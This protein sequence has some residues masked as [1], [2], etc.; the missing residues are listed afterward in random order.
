MDERKGIKMPAGCG[1]ISTRFWSARIK[2][3]V[4]KL[5]RLRLRN[6]TFALESMVLQSY[7]LV[8]IFIK[9]EK[10]GWK[11]E[12]WTTNVNL[13]IANKSKRKKMDTE[14]CQKQLTINSTNT[15]KM[16]IISLCTRTMNDSMTMHIVDR[17]WTRTRTWTGTTEWQWQHSSFFSFSSLT[18][19]ATLNHLAKKSI[20]WH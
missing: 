12:L 15:H 20:L 2:F 5:I 10:L 14:W 4:V 7:N 13:R 8:F 1:C 9:R 6:G 16:H 11:M 3:L 19:L 17:P 18:L